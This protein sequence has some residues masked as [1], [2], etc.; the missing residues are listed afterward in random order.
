MALLNSAISLPASSWTY[1]MTDLTAP[2]KTNFNALKKDA[3]VTKCE[4]FE[5]QI[6]AP[7]AELSPMDRRKQCASNTTVGIINRVL[8]ITRKDGSSVEGGY[9]FWLT[10]SIEINY[11]TIEAPDYQ[12]VEVQCSPFTAWDNGTPENP[13]PVGTELS[14]LLKDNDYAVVRL[15]WEFDGQ[16]KAN[17]VMKDVTN[18]DENGNIEPVFNALGEPLQKRGFN[19]APKKKVFAFDVLRAD[20]NQAKVTEEIPF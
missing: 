5:A 18:T 11:G 19:Y 3:L 7:A 15:Y 4:E 12:R 8:P 20:K 14:N 9:K 6:N 17:V 16:G 2:A 13:N 1:L 10:Q